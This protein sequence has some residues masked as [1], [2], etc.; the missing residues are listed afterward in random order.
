MKI[1]Y[2][3]VLANFKEM[4]REKMTIFWY[5]VFPLLF[6]FIFGTIFS[7]G[8]KNVS[9][10]IGLVNLDQGPVSTGI[11]KAFDKVS[12]FKLHEGKEKEELQALDNGKRSLV[13]VLPQELT[14]NLSTGKKTE[15]K[16]YYDQS[17]ADTNQTLLSTVSQIF[18]S[19]ERQITRAPE[20]LNPVPQGIR[21]KSLNQINYYIPGILA[22]TLMQLGLFGSLRLVTLREKKILRSLGA[23]PL[24]KTIFVSSEIFVRMIVSLVQAFLIVLVG[25]FVYDLKVIG[26]WFSL[27]GWVLFGSLAFISLGF[28]LVSFARTTESA[29]GVIQVFQF[30]MMFLAGI[31]IPL[32]IMPKFL[33]PV[34]KVIP[35]TYL[36]DAMRQVISG[37]PSQFSLS[38]DF[39]VLLLWFGI[40]AIWAVR[41]KW[42]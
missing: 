5:I 39:L 34:A 32:S 23:T 40:S 31:F 12:I 13:I 16:I 37:V 28:A 8:G 22:M 15:I 3:L 27:I 17:Q 1:F 26:N 33:E 36:A 42:E 10:D 41:F 11:V 18:N 35:L 21:A 7:G 20:L 24:P 6:V 9:Y 2:K 14:E 29:E 19:I 4:I 38:R 25:H 30:I